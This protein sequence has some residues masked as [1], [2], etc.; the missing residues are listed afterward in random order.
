[1]LSKEFYIEEFFV[2]TDFQNKGYGT[3]IL[4]FI[5]SDLKRKG[6]SSLTLLTEHGFP[7]EKFYEKNGFKQNNHLVFMKKKI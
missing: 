2:S 3:S 6:V 4:E 5:K 7:S 1:M